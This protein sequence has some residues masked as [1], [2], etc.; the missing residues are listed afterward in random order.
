ME[1]VSATDQPIEARYQKMLHSSESNEAVAI[2]RESGLC[3]ESTPID[4]E[5]EKF[6]RYLASEYE[7]GAIIHGLPKDS[8][9][10]FCK[11]PEL[12]TSL[13]NPIFHRKQST[14]YREEHLDSRCVKPPFP[15]SVLKF[16]AVSNCGL[17]SQVH[18]C[19]SK[20]RQPSELLDHVNNC[21]TEFIVGRG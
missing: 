21:R 19:I 6:M 15:F 17:S 16:E 5:D 18:V 11:N 13:P 9:I 7:R 4:K 2:S 8:Y 10:H 3:N 1:D 20:V 14:K 12:A